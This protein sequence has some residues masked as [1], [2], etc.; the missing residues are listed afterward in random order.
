MNSTYKNITNYTIRK[1]SL[2]TS[3]E[4]TDLGKNNQRMWKSEEWLL[5]SFIKTDEADTTKP[6][7]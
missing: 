3:N 6:T 2:G 5:G 4:I 1:L 7:D